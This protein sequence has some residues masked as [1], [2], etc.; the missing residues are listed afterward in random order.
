MDYYEWMRLKPALLPLLL[1]ISL[2][3]HAANATPPE[4]R[5][6]SSALDSVLFY[7]LLLGELNVGA[8][9]PGVAFSL[10]LDAARK[11]TDPA[12]YRRA[13]QI[14]IGARA[15]ESALQAAKA[16]SQ[17]LPAS[18]EANRFILQILLGLNRTAETLEPL[19]RAIALSP[20]AERIEL[21]W[22][23]PGLYERAQDRQL[24]ATTVQKALAD[25]LRDRA[26]GATAWAVVGRF[27]LGADNKAAA[28]D[29]ADKGLAID[30]KSEHPALL[31]LSMM[32]PDAPKAEQLVRQHLPHARPAFHLAYIKALLDAQRASEANAALDSLKTSFPAYPDAWLVAGVLAL[33]QKLPDLAEQQLLHYLDLV[34]AVATGDQPPEMKRGRAQAQMALAQIAQLR[35]EPQTAQAWLQLVDNPDDLLRAQIQLAMQLAQ[36]GQ[37]EAALALIQNQPERSEPDARLKRSAEIQLL[38]DFKQFERARGKLQAAIAQSPHDTDLVYELAMVTEKLN[39]LPEMERLLRSLIAIN[40]QDP[41]AYNALG[42]SLAER[43]L[44]LDEAKELI[45]KAL[46]LSPGDPFITDSLAWAEYR[47]GNLTEALRLLQTAFKNKPDAEIA[48]HLG[49]VLWIS[50]RQPEA[51]A[52][53]KAG[54]QLNPDNETLIDTLK[55]LRVPL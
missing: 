19:K 15:G 53:F 30:I 40:P 22:R 39:D 55:R 51:Q 49:E 24:V 47:S 11:T 9:D 50:Q 4:P 18:A 42:Y 31:A 12:V 23:L 2:G 21:L 20:A 14:A 3:A 46:L 1:S 7:Q 28:L 8:E 44:R 48:A 16:W 25:W 32:S 34:E 43:N 6:V 36:Q 17:A 29:A 33:Q 45:T 26:V 10:I 35:H 41:Q 37:L 13:M 54:L 38:R 27:W 5:P 52:I